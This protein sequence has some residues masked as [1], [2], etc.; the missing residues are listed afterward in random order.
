MDSSVMIEL[1]GH[2]TLYSSF[3]KSNA[4]TAVN[5]RKI[6]IKL[7]YTKHRKYKRMADG[8][9]VYITREKKQQYSTLI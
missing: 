6:T 5:Q 9:L 3:I 7:P 4:K 2:S 1:T 8:D